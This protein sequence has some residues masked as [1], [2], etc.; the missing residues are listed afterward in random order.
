D[1]YNVMHARGLMDRKFGPDGLRKARHRFLVDLAD[2][3]DQADAQATT[4]VFDARTP[5]DHL[6]NRQKLRGI[7]II[8]AVGDESADARIVS[9]INAHSAPKSLTAISTDRQI[10]QAAE[11]R[12]SKVM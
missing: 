5:P 12:K 8:F 1:G 11:R 10:R 4:V 9:M 6:P 2:S 7:T 3:L